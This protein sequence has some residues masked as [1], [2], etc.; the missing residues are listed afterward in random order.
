MKIRNVL[1]KILRENDVGQ[2]IDDD[3]E[4]ITASQEL[5]DATKKLND[6]KNKV[7]TKLRLA[8][9]AKIAAMKTKQNND[10]SNNLNKKNNQQDVTTNQI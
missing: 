8:Q 10:T 4:V 1:D 6:V 2:T 7:A 9:V 5:I 3:P